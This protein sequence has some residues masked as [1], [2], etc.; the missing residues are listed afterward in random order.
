MKLYR[1]WQIC[2]CYI[3]RRI[4]IGNSQLAISKISLITRLRLC[5]GSETIEVIRTV[6][7]TR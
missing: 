2:F 4:G 7:D 1:K 3:K 5:K 6:E